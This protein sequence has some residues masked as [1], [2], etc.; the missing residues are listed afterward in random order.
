MAVSS[1]PYK[2]YLIDAWTKNINVF[3]EWGNYQ[4]RLF[5]SLN[6]PKNIAI[7]DKNDFFFISLRSSVMY[8]MYI[9]YK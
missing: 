1:W 9:I 4:N 5:S 7:D 8:N 3:D 2:V 6:D